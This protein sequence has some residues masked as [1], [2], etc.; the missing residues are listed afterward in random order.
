MLRVA[1]T[2]GIGSGKSTVSARLAERGAVVVDSDRLAREVVAVGSPG[3]A[4]VVERF[5]A[6]VLAEDGSLNRPALAAIVFSE[7]E[8]RRA[9]E[10]ITHPR[11]RA[12]FDEIAAA[13]PADA[14]VVND[15][16][17][18]VALPVA[19]AFHTVVGVGA[20]VDVRIGRLAGRGLAG[21]DAR[22][23]IAA[24]I[25]NAAR[26]PLTDVWLDNN[27][28][29]D[30]LIAQVDALWD[31]RLR[32]FQ[33][34][35]LD[36]R[37]APRPGWL[38]VPADPSW[39]ADAA[40]L[41]ARVGRAAGDLAVHLAHIG[42]TAVPGLPAADVL[43]L[44][45]V[46][47]DLAAVPRVAPAL[48]RAGFVPVADAGVDRPHSADDDP[49]RWRRARHANADPGRA[50][51]LYVRPA[52]GPAWRW[53]IAFRDWLADDPAERD[54]FR[55]VKEGLAAEHAEDPDGAGYAAAKAAW[56]DAVDAPLRRW[57]ERTGWRSPDSAAGL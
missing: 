21:S 24:Q 13:A 51:D 43:D 33:D 45:L 32:P 37:P 23:R 22:A 2:G 50:V 27:G 47:P 10:G 56:F 36:G 19:A 29:A 11:V 7:P 57:V 12:R 38:P 9:L 30:V 39:P 18:L 4:A 46:V 53:A 8:A 41:L 5:G 55:A 3:L 48:A 1:V 14:V 52:A 15:I 34:L 44:Q 16:P 54:G 26:R 25:D 17:L 49:A 28:P 42:S 31:G 6:S 20:D 40:R 35:L